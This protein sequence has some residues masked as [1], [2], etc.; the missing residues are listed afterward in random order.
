MGKPGLKRLGV[1]RSRMEPC[2]GGCSYDKR[3]FKLSPEHITH[4][5]DLVDNAIHAEG[6]EIHEHDL[7][8]RA[9]PGS[10][11]TGGHSYD[12][13]FTDGCIHNAFWAVLPLENP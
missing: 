13:G 9:E 5:G 8:H 4:F 12:G 3:A 7:R 6:H 10:R 1:L 11:C 2:T